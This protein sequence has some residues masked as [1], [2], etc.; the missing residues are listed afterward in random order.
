[1]ALNADTV[2]LQTDW[3]HFPRGNE[4][5]K[6]AEAFGKHFHKFEKP[7]RAFFRQTRIAPK[8]TIIDC[9]EF[10]DGSV[11]KVRLDE[12]NEHRNFWLKLFSHDWK[13]TE[14]LPES[15]KMDISISLIQ[16]ALSSEQITGLD[17]AITTKETTRVL[18]SVPIYKA[19]GQT[20]YERNFSNQTKKYGKKLLPSWW[21][22]LASH[23]ELCQHVSSAR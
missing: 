18:E 14:D 1:M 4:K 15:A 9:V 20:G 17:R 13:E 5:R 2:A 8:Q 11:T 19:A 10:S 23:Q 12:Q 6:K 3:L 16:T 7:S 22:K 21:I